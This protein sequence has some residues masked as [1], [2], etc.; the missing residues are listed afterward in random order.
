MDTLLSQSDVFTKDVFKNVCLLLKGS[1]NSTRI[2]LFQKQGHRIKE[3]WADRME[4]SG[5]CI[6]IYIYIDTCVYYGKQLEFS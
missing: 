1:R 2:V 4:A 5:G 6:Y 3:G